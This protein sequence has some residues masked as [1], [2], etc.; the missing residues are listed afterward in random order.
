MK[1][2]MQY[3]KKGF[4]VV[5][6]NLKCLLNKMNVVMF[7]LI[8]NIPIA[9]PTIAELI[10]F[11]LPRY[12]GEK[13]K[14]LAPKDFKKPPLMVLNKITQNTNSTWNF[15]KCKITSCTGKE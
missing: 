10:A 3:F 15:L 2:L 11:T 12:S 14:A 5:A 7:Q 6:K 4:V 1:L 13:N 9:M 8:I